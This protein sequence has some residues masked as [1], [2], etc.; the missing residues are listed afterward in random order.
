MMFGFFGRRRR[1]QTVAVSVAQ[2]I[3]MFSFSHET[4][5]P[6]G[7]E[8]HLRGLGKRIE[9]ETIGDTRVVRASVPMTADSDLFV[10]LL[11]KTE[12]DQVLMIEGGYGDYAGFSLHCR[13][14]ATTIVVD[15]EP[16]A[17]AP[18]TK[19]A[20]LLYAECRT[21]PGAIEG[22]DFRSFT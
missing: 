10:S 2:L 22:R 21:M 8:R 15:L 1:A 20:R 12:A 3:H 19:L 14:P 16:P 7:P 5:G 18:M 13:L 6:K 4:L 11:M 9:E 17:R